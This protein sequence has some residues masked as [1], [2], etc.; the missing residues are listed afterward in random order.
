MSI[1]EKD[2]ENIG[3]FNIADLLAKAEAIGKLAE[4]EA[5]EADINARF[6][7][8]ISNEIKEAGF[9]KLMRPNRYGGIPIDLKTYGDIVRTV[10]RHSV[11]A[12]WLVYFYSI[13]EVWAAYLP[14]KG[15]DEIF[16]Q[17]GLLAD[18]VAPLGKVEK[19]IDGEGYRLSGRWNFCSGVLWSDWVGLGAVMELPDSKEPEYC[20]L[21]VP[22]SDITIVEN[23]DTLGVRASG[24]NGVT[25]ENAYVPI[26]RIYP[27]DRAFITGKPAGGD[28]DES[29]RVYRIPFVPLFTLGFPLVALGGA[30]RLISLFQE[31]TEKRVRI[32]KKGA[33]EKDISSSQRVLAELKLEFSAMEGLMNI[34]IEQ[35]HSWQV[36][37]KSAINDEERERLFAFR[38]QIAKSATDIATKVLLTLGGTAIF[39]GDPV[40]LFTRDL[41]ALAAHGSHHY[42]DSKAAYGRTLFGFAGDPVW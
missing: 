16:G 17:G 20:L 21:A 30:E 29:D 4:A 9:H 13:H 1:N 28:F 42:E 8:K 22:K 33:S 37:G 35:L 18:V 36:E 34:Y 41:L 15:R 23:W 26:H 11:A 39:K 10:S 31:R 25:V 27:A 3:N 6:S 2:L 38:G 19:D 40:E 32:F 24:S 14:R 12:G 7:D 5:K